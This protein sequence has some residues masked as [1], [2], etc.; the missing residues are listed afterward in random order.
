MA[1]YE[2]M[3]LPTAIIPQEVIDEYNL[4]ALVHNGHIYV[5]IQRGMY[6]LPQASIIANQLLTKRLE[7]H[8]Y[9]QCRHTPGL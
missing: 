6:G 2:Y 3:R 9:S 1:R 8:G 5:E 4:T 7:P